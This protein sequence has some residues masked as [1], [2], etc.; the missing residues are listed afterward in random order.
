MEL[1]EIL[2]P[3]DADLLRVELELDKQIGNI[4]DH[5][6]GEDELELRET[7]DYF[8][9][10]P[11]KRLRPALALLSARALGDVGSTD[12]LVKVATAAELIH[13]AS[14]IHDDVIDQEPIRRGQPT[15]SRLQGNT[16]AVLVG[17]LY[18][19]QFFSIL[20][21]LTAVGVERQHILFDIFLST[22]RKMCMAEILEARLERTERAPT[23]ANYLQII[24][25]KTASLMSASCEAAAVVVGAD[26]KRRRGIAQFG[27]SIG[28][29]YQL[30]DDALDGDASYRDG[31]EI[32]VKAEQMGRDARSHLSD[33][34][35]SASTQRLKAMVEYVL[36]KVKA[37]S[38][39]SA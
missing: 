11:G 3:I 28:L 5:A 17:D 22:T 16:V 1:R 39:E 4:R 14:L 8:F 24:E 36:E 15:L 29:A 34:P 27:R 19:A 25:D 21:E 12:L 38:A 23:L 37:L 30:V 10:V 35:P 2:E 6:R 31:E 26:E 18:Y 9:G 20:T 33:L 13:S 32:L 7:V